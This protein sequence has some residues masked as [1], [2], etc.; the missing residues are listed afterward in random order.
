MRVFKWQWMSCLHANKKRQPK[1]IFHA[2]RNWH[3]FTWLPLGTF[4]A[5]FTGSSI[6]Y[7]ILAV[8]A[9]VPLVGV[10]EAAAKAVIVRIRCC[11]LLLHLVVSS[12][13]LCSLARQ[14]QA[15]G[16]AEQKVHHVGR[17]LQMAGDSYAPCWCQSVCGKD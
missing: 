13:V 3:G 2:G 8:A 5:N 11:P 6:A 1:S 10:G 15:G 14:V 7:A 12:Y 9:V 4:A 16:T 17:A